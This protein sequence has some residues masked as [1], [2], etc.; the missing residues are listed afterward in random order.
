M[1]QFS[2]RVAPF[3]LRKP[4]NAQMPSGGKRPHLL[5][6]LQGKHMGHSFLF[7][8]QERHQHKLMPFSVA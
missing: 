4:Q 7:N 6:L 1:P 3:S 5:H 2:Q 8:V